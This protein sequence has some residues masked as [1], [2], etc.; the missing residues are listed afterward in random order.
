MWAAI[1]GGHAGIVEI[2][3]KHGANPTCKCYTNMNCVTHANQCGDAGIV[4]LLLD[5]IASEESA[6]DDSS[7]TD[8][9]SEPDENSESDEE[10]L[11]EDD[12]D[13]DYEDSDDEYDGFDKSDALWNACD[14]GDETTVKRL[15]LRDA[16]GR[17]PV[18]CCRIDRKFH[19]QTPLNIAIGRGHEGVVKLLLD[20]RCLASETYRFSSRLGYGF[21]G[22]M[23]CAMEGHTKIMQMLLDNDATSTF[24]NQRSAN[25]YSAIDFAVARNRIDMVRA[26][27]KHGAD[28]NLPH[29]LRGR[30]PLFL[31][32]GDTQT[33]MLEILLAHGANPSH[34]ND[35]GDTAFAEEILNLIPKTVGIV[36]DA[37]C[38]V[39]HQNAK[40]VTLLHMC[41]KS[42]LPVMAEFLLKRGAS[43]DIRA[44][45]GR[46]ASDVA[47]RNGNVVVSDLIKAER[48]RRTKCVAFC[49]GLNQ[50]LGENSSVRLLDEGVVRMIADYV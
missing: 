50:R 6:D 30:S 16:N 14:E 2:L 45:S 29:G 26:M 23:T 40:G 35:Y 36:L 46:T 17:L 4:K 28:V 25:G 38:E 43:I 21:T 11:P 3:L 7:Y 42:D 27:L 24:V 49:M 10:V 37:G 47:D 22:M 1:D 15:I 33:E 8:E 41:A 39:D 5:H 18:S 12:E 19:G 9:N 20:S 44:G 31:A 48:V 34:V 13:S 32:M